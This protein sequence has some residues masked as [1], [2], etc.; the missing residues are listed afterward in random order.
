MQGIDLYSRLRARLIPALELHTYL[1]NLGHARSCRGDANYTEDAPAGHWVDESGSQRPFPPAILTCRAGWKQPLVSSPLLCGGAT[2]KLG[3]SGTRETLLR[4]LLQTQ[5]QTASASQSPSPPPS[6]SVSGL[7]GAD[8]MP[9]SPDSKTQAGPS[10]ASGRRRVKSAR[11]A[12]AARSP[13]RAASLPPQP[14]TSPTVT[15]TQTPTAARG[16]LVKWG[17]FPSRE[18]RNA[19]NTFDIAL[20]AYARLRM[21]MP[22][23]AEFVR[24]VVHTQRYPSDIYMHVFEPLTH[25]EFPADDLLPLPFSSVAPRSVSLADSFAAVFDSGEAPALAA[26]SSGRSSRLTLLSPPMLRWP[27]ALF[28][29]GETVAEPAKRGLG[30]KVTAVVSLSLAQSCISE[31]LLQLLPRHAE[32][33]RTPRPAEQAGDNP[34]L[35][36]PSQSPPLPPEQAAGDPSDLLPGVPATSAPEGGVAAVTDVSADAAGAA[37]GAAAADGNPDAHQQLQEEVAEEAAEPFLAATVAVTSVALDQLRR[38]T[39]AVAPLADLQG[40]LSVAAAAPR[41]RLLAKPALASKPSGGSK[42]ARRDASKMSYPSKEVKVGAIPSKGIRKTAGT[43]SG[44]RPLR[45]HPRR[46]AASSVE[47]DVALSPAWE[48][49]SG[50]SVSPAGWPPASARRVRLSASMRL[51]LRGSPSVVAASVRFPLSL[52]VVSDAACVRAGAS[53]CVLLGRDVLLDT[54][55]PAGLL[56]H[57][58]VQGGGGALGGPVV[59]PGTRPEP[60]LGVED[61]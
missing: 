29:T 14:S 61:Q 15:P 24:T 42:P 54:A 19:T 2:L 49:E 26:L 43:R 1:L 50:D 21:P 30:F 53:A 37:A 27:L 59:D 40:P 3:S 55:H 6:T 17:R 57:L 9:F 16:K 35:P 56:L 18:A 60:P 44:H 38:R 25:G 34:P 4:D 5:S 52:L 20:S 32:L 58:L 36:S 12:T 48:E 33:D 23:T 13:G 22:H 47:A 39:E 41:R 10:R 51:W 7:E 8:S 11:G 45:R 28:P 31:R 46:Y